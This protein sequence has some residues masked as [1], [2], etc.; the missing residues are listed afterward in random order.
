MKTKSLKKEN[1]KLRKKKL[2]LF[3]L[4]FVLSVFAQGITDHYIKELIRL[5]L[6]KTK[7]HNNKC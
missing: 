3:M 2:F 5:P 1:E 4:E 6:H 7:F